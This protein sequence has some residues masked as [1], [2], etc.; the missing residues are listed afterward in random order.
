MAV[1]NLLCLRRMICDMHDK[2]EDEMIVYII[3]VRS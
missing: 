2:L 3:C 1:K